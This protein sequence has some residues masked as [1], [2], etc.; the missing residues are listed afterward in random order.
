MTGVG[1]GLGFLVFAGF[2]VGGATVGGSSVGVAVGVAVTTATTGAREGVADGCTG[3]QAETSATMKT[4]G[5]KDRQAKCSPRVG[6]ADRPVRD[7]FAGR[8]RRHNGPCVP[9][10]LA[11]L[12]YHAARPL[13]RGSTV[14][15]LTLD[16]GV[17]G[18]NPGAPA[19]LPSTNEGLRIARRAFLLAMSDPI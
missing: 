17:P 5:M 14:E 10:I 6:A 8:R 7:T 2:F 15:H 13:A 3:E 16:Q 1:V 9:R 4:I 19:K 18:S 12:G 11:P